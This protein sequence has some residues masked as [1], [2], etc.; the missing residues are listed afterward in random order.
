MI[1]SIS[2]SQDE[3]LDNIRQLYNEGKQF[4]LDP[5]YSKGVFYK[6]KQRPQYCFDLI[7][8]YD[9][10]EKYDCRNLPFDDNTIDSIIFDP[11]FLATTGPSL[12]KSENNN[13]IN[14]RFGVYNSEHELFQM[15]KDSIAEFSR[16]LKDSGL[17]VVKCQDKI[18]SGK[19]YIA[20]NTIINYA[21]E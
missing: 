5:C 9:F 4:Q 8:Q 11:P 20:H 2:Y 15:Y 18:S 13:H 7:P 6:G 21:Q 1:K 10:V 19:Q 12:K 16:V 3:I 14:K 17:L